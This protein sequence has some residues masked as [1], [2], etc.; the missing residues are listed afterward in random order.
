[1]NKCI[2]QL[3]HTESLEINGCSDSMHNTYRDDSSNIVYMDDIE[4]ENG[5][6]C[7]F[8][9]CGKQIKTKQELEE[10]VSEHMK[11][12]LFRCEY[13][14]CEKAYKSR[15]NMT[16]HFKNIHLKQKPYKCRFCAANFSH[17]NGKY[18]LFNL[19]KTYHER[20]FH[21]NYLPYKCNIESI[22]YQII[23]R[24]YHQLR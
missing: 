7:I 17:R 22:F 16:L 3:T 15:E 19:G 21:I 14:G 10:H 2:Y 8:E 1:M 5:I 4:D 24:L 9:S 13:P 20:K 12:R 18:K 11:I 23:L 6:K